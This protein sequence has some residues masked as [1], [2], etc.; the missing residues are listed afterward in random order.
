M[1][2]AINVSRIKKI[3]SNILNLC[4]NVDTFFLKENGLPQTK[5]FNQWYGRNCSLIYKCLPSQVC[6]VNK[7]GFFIL[8]PS[9]E[10]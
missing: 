8:L 9:N 4:K 5:G 6:T 1:S 3:K 7:G 2:S 10:T